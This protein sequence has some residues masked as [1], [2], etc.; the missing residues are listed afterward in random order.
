MQRKLRQ[1]DR[2]RRFT[3]GRVKRKEREKTMEKGIPMTAREVERIAVMTG[4]GKSVA[5][6]AGDLNRSRNTIYAYITAIRQA[7][8]GTFV[9]QSESRVRPELIEPYMRKEGEAK[10]KE[11][12]LLKMEVRM[13]NRPEIQL[14][15]TGR[16]VLDPENALLIAGE[17]DARTPVD[18]ITRLMRVDIATV[19][20]LRSYID[21]LKAGDND[22]ALSVRNSGAF[23]LPV[24]E[25][26][27]TQYHFSPHEKSPEDLEADFR[28]SVLVS[29]ELTTDLLNSI[30]D[31]LRKLVKMLEKNSEAV[32]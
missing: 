17:I 8:Q 32:N 6:I 1:K 23:P 14:D 26:L 28:H 7:A 27:E 15:R 19:N 30:D 25:A 2:P 29:Q 3:P 10:E 24:F 11:K 20:R 31:L 13:A 16:P 12:E 18:I 21:L 5:E 22:K 4:A 9:Y